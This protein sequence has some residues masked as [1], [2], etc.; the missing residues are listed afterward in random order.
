MLKLNFKRW[1]KVY[2]LGGF[3]TLTGPG[4]GNCKKVKDQSGTLHK[5][6][7][8]GNVEE[9]CNALFM[10]L[11]YLIC[12]FLFICTLNISNLL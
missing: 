3:P 2:F 6:K 5:H 11:N 4:L 8:F 9:V 12:V 1:S 7:L 10:A